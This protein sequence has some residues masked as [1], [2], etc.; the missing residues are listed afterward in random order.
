MELTQIDKSNYLKGLL[1]VAKKDNQLSDPEK[2]MLKN[3]AKELGF[4]KDFYEDTIRNLLSNKYIAEDPIK[5][6]EPK[7]AESF[8]SDGLKLAFADNQVSEKE[9]SWLRATASENNLD[10]DW[11]ENKRKMLSES[12]SDLLSA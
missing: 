3:T 1:I 5:F 8:I 2:T 12:S 9:I 4:A 10:D 7:V 11:F 6:S